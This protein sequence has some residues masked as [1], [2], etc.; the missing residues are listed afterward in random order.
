MSAITLSIW[1]EKEKHQDAD[2]FFAAYNNEIA[3]IMK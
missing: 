1:Q 2:A 3:E